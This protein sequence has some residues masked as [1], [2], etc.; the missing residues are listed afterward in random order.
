M[1]KHIALLCHTPYVS[2]AIGYTRNYGIY[3][4]NIEIY[5][6]SFLFHPKH[7]NHIPSSKM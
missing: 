5:V 7:A 3:I 1:L 2:H 4:P 6:V